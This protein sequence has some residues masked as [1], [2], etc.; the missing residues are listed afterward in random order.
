M[1]EHVSPCI[2]RAL[3]ADSEQMSHLWFFFWGMKVCGIYHRPWARCA[4]RICISAIFVSLLVSVPKD[5]AQ[6]VLAG[7]HCRGGGLSTFHA[8]RFIVASIRRA[9]VPVLFRQ[10]VQGKRRQNFKS[11]GTQA[12]HGHVDAI[13]YV[14]CSG[15]FQD[16]PSQ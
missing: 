1:I 10:R 8:Q 2:P 15:S 14:R 4:P 16:A 11:P 7:R 3:V 12:A 13:S 5:Q 6:F 9:A